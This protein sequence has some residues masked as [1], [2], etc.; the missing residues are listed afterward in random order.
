[1]LFEEII[2]TVIV[3]I[4]ESLSDTTLVN[5]IKSYINRGYKDLAKKENLEKKKIMTINSNAFKMPSDGFDIVE[6][7]SD[8]ERIEYALQGRYVAL[9]DTYKEITLVYNYLPDNLE[10]LEDETETNEANI[11][12][13]IA[14]A[15]YLYFLSEMLTDDAKICKELMDKFNFVVK[16]KM[17]RITK[18][19]NV[20][21]GGE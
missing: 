11:E 7:L 10:E 5:K 20:Y 13:I 2:N 12:Y 19:K 18:I 17:A 3:D 8:G 4:D 14:Y 15:K 6:V 21:G 9:N 1:M 16:D